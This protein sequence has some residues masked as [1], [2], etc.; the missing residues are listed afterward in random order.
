VIKNGK[1][2]IRDKYKTKENEER[3]KKKEK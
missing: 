1:K 2:Y 3:K